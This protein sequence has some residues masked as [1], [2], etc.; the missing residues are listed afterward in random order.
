[1]ESRFG[2]RG[3]VYDGVFFTE[4]QITG[5]KVIRHLHVEIS[6]QNADL[7]GGG[8]SIASTPAAGA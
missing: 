7:S 1:M 2:V 3:T 8:A 6:L 5:A 4:A